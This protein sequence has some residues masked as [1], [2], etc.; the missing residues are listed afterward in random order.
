M[1]AI[2][3]KRY[4]GKNKVFLYSS[5]TKAVKVHRIIA[6]IAIISKSI[7]KQRGGEILY[8][9]KTCMGDI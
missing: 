7:L 9:K 8:S 1:S 4:P 2:I 6:Q 5:S 3:G